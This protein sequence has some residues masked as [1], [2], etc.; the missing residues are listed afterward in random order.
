LDAA[1][2][3]ATGGAII[4]RTRTAWSRAPALIAAAALANAL[5]F[6]LQIL[7]GFSV[8]FGDAYDTVI[9]AALLEH[10][11][12]VLR[13]LAPWSEPNYFYPHALVLGYNDGYL[14][15]GLIY[16]MFRA[17]G[18]DP[19]LSSELVN[20]V[21]KLIG[22]FAFFAAARRI[23]KLPFGWAVFGATLFT[24][25][26][27]GFINARHAQLLSVSFAPVMALLLWE[28]WRA[29]GSSRGGRIIGFGALSAS[30]YSAWLLTAFY[31]AWFFAFFC[32]ALAAILLIRGGKPGI[33]RLGRT[34][35]DNRGPLLVVLVIFLLALAP[36][37]IVYLPKA[38]ETGM[39]TFRDA[40]S[41]TPAIKDIVNVGPGNLL[42]GNIYTAAMKTLCSKCR[43]GFTAQMTGMAPILLVLF[44]F[45]VAWLGAGRNV[46]HE[47]KLLSGMALTTILTW[48]LCLHVGALSGWLLVYH[49]IPGAKAIRVV[50]RYPIFLMAPVTA[51]AVC[52]LAALARRISRPTVVALCA[53]L[54]AGEIDRGATGAVRLDRE[55]ELRRFSVPPPPPECRAFFVSAAP[56]QDGS[57]MIASL[58]PHNVDAM[59]IAE[60][61]NLPTI[62]GFASFNPPD[63]DFAGPDLPD[64]PARVE[65]YAARY[66]LTG[67]CRLDLGTLSWD[68][69]RRR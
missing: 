3:P 8:L 52:Y 62:N 6:R 24:L 7:N 25:N 65:R 47:R 11:F 54:L 16:S 42:F 61:V 29:L 57:S 38:E 12:N 1:P 66:D 30:F 18:I 10:W 60:L 40:V 33:A 28:T 44:G 4:S 49:L 37:L 69:E 21:V 19:L 43:T 55:R 50:A 41:S 39:R 58:Y 9:E 13:G 53:L 5:F 45:A 68:E 56:G 27:A 48:V 63:W 35:A 64:Y 26:H 36:F 22:F 46:I 32:M 2:G 17:F 34:I 59:M 51:V 20:V 67:L 15:F 14:I 31:M 23:L